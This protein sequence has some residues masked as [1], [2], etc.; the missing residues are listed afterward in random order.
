MA[1][2]KHLGCALSVVALLAGAGVFA[3]AVWADGECVASDLEGLETCLADA[4]AD[5]ITTTN[6]IVVSGEGIDKTLVINKNITGASGKD[7]FHIE[8]GA[9]LTLRGSGMI[10]AGRYGAVADG[11]ELVIDGVNIDA[12][13]SA[14]YG[15]YA[16]DN[17]RVTMESGQVIADYAAFA[18]NNTTGDMNFY[19]NGGLLKSNRYPAIYMP[20]QVDLVMRGGTLEGGIVARMGQI[21]IEEGTI[22]QQANPVAGDGL[23]VNYSGMPSMANEAI[24]LVAGSYKSATT[25]YGND[26][27][28]TISGGNTRINGSVVLY[29]L[30]NTAEDFAQNVNVRIE[31]GVFTSFETKFTEEEIGFALRNGYTAGLNHEAG[32]IN[33][34]LSGGQYTVEP[35]E[36][37]ILPGNEAEY[38]EDSGYY[39]I[40]PINVDYNDDWFEA[41]YDD[42]YAVVVD[43]KS[44]FIAD[45]KADLDVEVVDPDSLHLTGS[46]EL[47]GALDLNIVNRDNVRIEVNDVDMTIYIDIDE[48]VYEQLAAYDRI[49][50]VYFDDERN[51]VER[52]DAKLENYHDEYVNPETGE[53]FSWDYYWIEFNTNHLSTYGVVG[54]NENG[55]SEE[56]GESEGAAATDAASSP[57]T[58]T[59]TAQGSSAVSA[60]LITAV[61]VGF[62]AMIA[63]FAYLV[64][65][66]S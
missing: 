49:E 39:E 9:K 58:G 51:E 36:E 24:T 28:L 6:T 8:N 23:D 60:A 31:G 4:G 46:G 22:N 5:S 2:Y 29:D 14:C 53:T 1:K 19:I 50:V 64:R 17:G 40:W 3:P 11:A 37:D 56:N 47:L 38:D 52:I 41:L 61:A 32:R 63:S 34:E 55:G 45:R 16:K 21:V 42:N 48:D 10:A 26:M 62:M 33:V 44:E 43:I 54:V 13:N 7:V 12:T 66:K 35:D 20:G 59:M 25:D 15:V 30:G 27:N 18:G 57:E 65:R